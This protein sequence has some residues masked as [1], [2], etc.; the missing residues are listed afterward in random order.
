HLDVIL[1]FGISFYT[2]QTMSYTIDIY[3]GDLIP[4]RRFDDFA[5]FVAFFPH[6]VAGPIMRAKDLIP[7]FARARTL[8]QVRFATACWLIGWGFWKKVFVADNMALLTNPVFAHSAT[9]T[10]LE[11]YLG[12]VA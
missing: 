12:V 10:W 8:D 6:L 9:V 7:Q 2:F 5:L 11:A 4:C 3:R 1:P